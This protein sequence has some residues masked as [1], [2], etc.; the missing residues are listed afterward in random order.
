MHQYRHFTQALSI[1][2]DH[3]PAYL[4]NPM[5]A[6]EPSPVAGLDSPNAGAGIAEF[7]ADC[8]EILTTTAR[9]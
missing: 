1:I 7:T 6:L 2:G 8:E 4:V 3:I 9:R 5:L